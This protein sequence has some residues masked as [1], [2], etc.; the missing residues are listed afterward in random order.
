MVPCICIR[1]PKVSLLSK[2]KNI[3]SSQKIILNW[4]NKQRYG[5][6]SKCSRCV[7]K[8]DCY[9]CP[10]KGFL[11]TKDMRAPVSYFCKLAYGALSRRN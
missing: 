11:E 3:R 9:K 7:Y 5:N 10:G 1:N 2:N 6:T 8:Q 4:I